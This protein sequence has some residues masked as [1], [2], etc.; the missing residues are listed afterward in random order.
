MGIVGHLPE[1]GVRIDLERS[2]DG[3]PPWHYTGEAV[4]PNARFA[5]TA[6][7]SGEGTVHVELSP[8]ASEVIAGRTRLL[9]RAVWK[10]A[11]EEDAAPP[12]RIV[13][14]RADR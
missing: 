10:H 6:T 2:R 13:R 11:C 8:D 3:G 7:V 4:T 12:R 9:L 14:W 5:M 1:S